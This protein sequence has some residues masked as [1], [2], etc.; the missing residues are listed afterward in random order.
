M[1]L[2]VLQ[3]A[4]LLKQTRDVLILTHKN[5]DGDRKSVV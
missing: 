1:R 2:T 3:T 5:P 4:E